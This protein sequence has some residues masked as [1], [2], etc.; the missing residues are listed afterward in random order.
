MK[1]LLF[2]LFSLV[3][4]S[5]SGLNVTTKFTCEFG[6]NT[7]YY[8][9][10][11]ENGKLLST[12]IAK[13]NITTVIQQVNPKTCY[14]LTLFDPV[15]S[16]LVNNISFCMQETNID[17]PETKFGNCP[18][19]VFGVIYCSDTKL[20]PLDFTLWNI[21]LDNLTIKKTLKSTTLNADGTYVI[22]APG[23]NANETNENESNANEGPVYSVT[24]FSSDSRV[25]GKTRP[26]TTLND[27]IVFPFSLVNCNS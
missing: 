6:E 17:L 21:T 3:L 14:N 13:N 26:F 16:I 22:Q 25:A 2:S 23:S 4:Q 12:T 24:F 8:Q 10:Y 15:D 7:L 5:V 9:L 20:P 1:F 19:F 11:A 18:F 27:Y